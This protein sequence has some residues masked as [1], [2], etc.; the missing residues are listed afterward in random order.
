MNAERERLLDELAKLYMRR[1][2]RD[3]LLSTEQLDVQRHALE[4]VDDAEAAGAT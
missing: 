4:P 1:A 2:L 3:F